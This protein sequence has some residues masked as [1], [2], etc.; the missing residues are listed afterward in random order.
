MTSSVKWSYYLLVEFRG[1]GAAKLAKRPLVWSAQKGTRQ[2]RETTYKEKK[3]NQTAYVQGTPSVKPHNVRR[4]S[5]EHDKNLRR[6]K[7]WCFSTWKLSTDHK[8]VFIIDQNP[9]ATN[10]TA[11]DLVLSKGFTTFSKWKM[12]PHS[13]T[14]TGQSQWVTSSWQHPNGSLLLCQ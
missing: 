4:V 11:V 7:P 5:E 1:A 6:P 2:V 9:A 13:T 12:S 8:I 10:R 3:K 14:N